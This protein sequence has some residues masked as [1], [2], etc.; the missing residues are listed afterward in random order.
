MNALFL[1]YAWNLFDIIYFGGNLYG[2]NVSIKS[3]TISLIKFYIE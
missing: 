3:M 1:F 2:F